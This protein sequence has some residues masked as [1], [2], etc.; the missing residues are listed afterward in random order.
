MDLLVKL[1][2]A[3]KRVNLKQI[4]IVIMVAFLVTCLHYQKSPPKSTWW[5]IVIFDDNEKWSKVAAGHFFGIL[6]CRGTC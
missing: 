3:Q 5:N 4:V 1:I 6:K 2:Y